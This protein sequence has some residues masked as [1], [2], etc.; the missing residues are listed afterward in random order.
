MEEQNGF[1]P[2]NGAEILEDYFTRIS[3][4]FPVASVNS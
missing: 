3:Q 4:M 2:G 1:G